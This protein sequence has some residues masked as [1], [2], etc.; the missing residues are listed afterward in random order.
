ML[1]DVQV[2]QRTDGLAESQVARRA[3]IEEGEP[4]FRILLAQQGHDRPQVVGRLVDPG[5]EADDIRPF[6]RQFGTHQQRLQP[7]LANVVAPAIPEHVLVEVERID[8]TLR[9]RITQRH[10]QQPTS[11]VA[12]K[13]GRRGGA[14]PGRRLAHPDRCLQSE[15]RESQQFGGI[16]LRADFNQRFG[17]GATLSGRTKQRRLAVG[18][19][20]SHAEHS[21]CRRMD[22]D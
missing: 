12:G 10:Q 19:T 1:L 22:A 9:D 17:F 11:G 20:A 4:G 7:D 5:L 2:D 21:A 13:G 16:H 6:G 15:S 14:L 18:A 3:G 8:L